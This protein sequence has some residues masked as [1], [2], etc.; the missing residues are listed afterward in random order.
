MAMPGHSPLYNGNG[1]SSPPRSFNNAYSEPQPPPSMYGGPTRPMLPPSPQHFPPPRFSQ[2][3]LPAPSP[4]IA[5]SN[6]AAVAAAP[7][8]HKRPGSS[9]SISSM[10]GT[11]P[12]R[13]THEQYPQNLHSRTS[14]RQ[15]SISGPPMSLG[16]VMSP[17]QYPSKP[18]IGDYSWK[19]RSKTPDRSAGSSLGPRTHRSSSGTMTQ[20]PGSLYEPPP[21]SGPGAYPEPRYTPPFG[22]APAPK[23]EYED[24]TRRT[25]ISGILQSLQQ[26]PESQPQPST[27]TTFQPYSNPPARPESNPTSMGHG[28]RPPHSAPNGPDHY[29][30]HG[31]IG[32][33]DTRPPSQPPGQRYSQNVPPPQSASTSDR[34]LP[35]SLSPELRRPQPHLSENRGLAGLL[36][37]S[38]ESA[39]GAQN[40]ARQDSVQSQ[41]DRS[42]FGDRL[43][44]TRPYSPFAG[45]VASQTALDDQLRKGSDEL[46]QH[47]AILGLANESKRGRYS[48]LPQAVQG[49]QAQTPQPDAGIKTE[50]GRVFSGIGSGLGSAQTPTPQPA[51]ATPSKRDE[52][53][54]RLSEENLMKMS[55]STSGITK[56]NRKNFDE[57]VRAESDMG[58]IKK[59]GLGRGK[60]AK[61]QHSY[62]TEVEDSTTGNRRNGALAPSNQHRR[63]PTPTS[64]PSQP[65]QSHDNH[66]QRQLPT[67]DNTPIHR[68]RRTIRIFSVVALARRNP[69]RHLG[70]FNYDPQVGP[71]DIEKPSS[72]K[73]DIAIRPNLLPSFTDAEHVNC[74]YTVRVPRIW[75]RERERFLICQ[76]RYLWGS[77]IYTDDS[78][79]VAAAMH[80]GFIASVYPSGI[81]EALLQKVID[82]QT[83][84]IEGSPAPKK[85]MP[86]DEN[87]DLHITLLVLPQLER[88]VDSVRFGIKSR[89]WPDGSESPASNMPRSGSSNSNNNSK[90][91]KTPHD[92]VSFMVLKVEFVDD[93]AE[94][95]R[96]GRTGKERRER[97]YRELLERKR[98]LELEKKKLDTLA[99]KARKQK[100]GGADGSKP[101]SKSSGNETGP[102]GD[103]AAQAKSR[104]RGKGNHDQP[105]RNN[106]TDGNDDKRD[107]DMKLDVGQSPGDWIRQLAVA[108]A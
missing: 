56:R 86:V 23:D 95:K 65:Q 76:E 29:R 72:P 79:P 57:D 15:P 13:A 100:E 80:S 83:P 58:D 75:L 49:A 7:A 10:L 26:R 1:P 63:A 106:N 45:S 28:D 91:P 8:P 88:Y 30:P 66:P 17:P 9:M 99:D 32:T 84:V 3:P 24:R 27:A 31:L 44:G 2:P 46:S 54:S 62:K 94:V 5:P 48:P 87:K 22:S 18:S 60:R 85:P 19:T 97:L 103:S 96:I 90:S 41:S 36:H 37:Q 52:G 71:I 104:H 69:R 35:Q 68:F 53:G 98:S 6:G 67:A 50:H 82:E 4:A 51:S 64:N 101:G 47:R 93:G 14:S 74:T 42:V 105:Q 34:A 59:T 77:G 21:R 38:S 43:R 107:D 70:F 39:Y 20:R 108:A 40:M 89:S 11:E 16:A 102:A 55:R 81:D 61:Y 73:F 92:G 12:E 33:Y 78:D 25:S